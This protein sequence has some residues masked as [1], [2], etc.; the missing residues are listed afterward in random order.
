MC[1]SLSRLES[2]FPPMLSS[3]TPHSHCASC[4][5]ISDTC[6]CSPLT[7]YTSSPPYFRLCYLV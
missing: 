6:L 7:I 2:A 4:S 1:S 3:Y 5:I